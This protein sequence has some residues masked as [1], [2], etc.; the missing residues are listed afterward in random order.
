MLSAGANDLVTS[1]RY[2]QHAIKALPRLGIQNLGDT[3]RSVRNRTRYIAYGH[4]DVRVQESFHEV[5]A[6]AFYLSLHDEI[7]RQLYSSIPRT[8]QDAYQEAVALI[9]KKTGFPRSK[10]L[11][12][13]FDGEIGELLELPAENRDSMSQQ[14]LTE[15]F[16][17]LLSAK[18]YSTRE[19]IGLF[20]HEEAF[21]DTTLILIIDIFQNPAKWLQF[22]INPRYFTKE[23]LR[24]YQLIQENRELLPGNNTAFQV[25]HLKARLKKQ[26][27]DIQNAGFVKEEEGRY[28]QIQVSGSIQEPSKARKIALEVYQ[29]TLDNIKIDLSILKNHLPF[30]TLHDKAQA[31]ITAIQQ[32][33]NK[34]EKSIAEIRFFSKSL[35]LTYRLL[36]PMNQ[37]NNRFRTEYQELI[38]RGEGNICKKVLGLMLIFL[39]AIGV[40]LNLALTAASYGLAAPGTITGLSLSSAAI[41][42]GIG[43]FRSGRQCPYAKAMLEFEQAARPRIRA[44]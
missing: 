20:H 18:L 10:D 34:P 33:M 7:H 41:L 9:Q 28:L 19:T 31:V 16:C 44:A 14:Q 17:K 42:G 6:C 38:K 11:V 37:K 32:E 2:G 26:A 24:L 13:A 3:E 15:N 35:A 43:L 29:N 4:P 5:H 23:Y 40:T 21:L 1:I 39:G 22:N 30:K 27:I 25:A 12:K 8:L 36:N